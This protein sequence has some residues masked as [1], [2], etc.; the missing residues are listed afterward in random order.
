MS[1]LSSDILEDEFIPD[2]TPMLPFERCPCWLPPDDTPD[3]ES[4]VD[5]FPFELS[6]EPPLLCPADTYE[7]PVYTGRPLSEP[8]ETLS[9]PCII[10][11]SDT[12]P[13]VAVIAAFPADL[14]V[15][16]TYILIT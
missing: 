9:I 16:C 2:D 12:V 5:V 13:T 7:S 4:P 1:E 8:A 3:C 10:T 14:T 11:E 15:Y 6:F